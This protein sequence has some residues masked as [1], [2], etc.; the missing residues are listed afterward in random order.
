M[1]R[2][3]RKAKTGSVKD[4]TAVAEISRDLSEPTSFNWI[5][6]CLLVNDVR[7]CETKER[8]TNFNKAVV[9]IFDII[10]M[11]FS[12]LVKKTWSYRIGEMFKKKMQTTTALRERQKISD[13]AKRVSPWP[14]SDSGNFIDA[15]LNSRDLP[16]NKYRQSLLLL[17][18]ARQ[19]FYLLHDDG[20]MHE[21]L[22][23]KKINQIK[24][25]GLDS[26]D[27]PFLKNMLLYYCIGPSS[28]TV[29]P[30]LRLQNMSDAQWETQ[31]KNCQ[32]R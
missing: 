20:G 3:A 23:A 15:L 13:A 22:T 24:D 30:L 32:G 7:V 29:R 16:T 8:S 9:Y 25:K 14:D 10:P 17:C 1:E 31:K 11:M 5:D 27:M 2:Q 6:K 4:K 12:G 19:N 18:N 26:W 21:I 28:E